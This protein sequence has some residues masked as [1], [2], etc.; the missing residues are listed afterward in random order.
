MLY[1]LWRSDSDE[2]YS[3]RYFPDMSDRHSRPR[4]EYVVWA[5]E[6][7]SYAEALTKRNEFLGW[8]E[9]GGLD[10]FDY[11]PDK[12]TFLCCYDYGSGGVWSFVAARSEAEIR[13]RYPELDVISNR[14]EFFT[15]EDLWRI[16]ESRRADVD[17]EPS[18]WFA[19]LVAGR[20]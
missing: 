12:R 14:P 7:D 8:G 3:L 5:G 10:V 9:T 16:W 20:S 18:G 6:A 19:T 15:Q 13:G 4:D 17:E 11:P 1:E 2:S